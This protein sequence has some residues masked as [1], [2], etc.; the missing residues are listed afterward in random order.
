MKNNSLKHYIFGLI[1][2]F[3]VIPLIEELMTVVNTWIQVLL[4]KPNKIV[5]KG[6]KELSELQGDEE[7]IETHCIGFQIPSEDD[8]EDEDDF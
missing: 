5:I 2:G 6:N 8:Y 7:P 4:L 3:I 1:T